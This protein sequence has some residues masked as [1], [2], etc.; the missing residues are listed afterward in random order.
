MMEPGIEVIHSDYPENEQWKRL[1][2]YTYPENVK[3]FW[4]DKHG[5]DPIENQVEAVTSAFTQAA[6]Y[7]HAARAVTMHTLPLLLYYG[8]VNLLYGV[9]CLLRGSLLDIDNHGMTISDPSGT[10]IADVQV[11]LS[12]SKHGAYCQFESVFVDR[13]M[14]ASSTEW[15]LLELFGSIPDL[16]EDFC[17]CYVNVEPFVIPVERVHTNDGDLERVVKKDYTRFHSIGDALVRVPGFTE[18]Y[19]PPQVGEFVI[20]RKKLMGGEIGVYSTSGRKF[21]ALGHRKNGHEMTLPPLLVMFVVLFTLSYLSRYRAVIWNPFVRGDSTGERLFVETLLET[22]LRS[23]PTL[24][25]GA[26]Y[27]RRIQFAR[28]DQGV[29]DRRTI[30]PEAQI[31]S[32]I[33]E[34]LGRS[35]WSLLGEE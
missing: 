18:T 22:C 17:E 13:A 3:R 20:L 6:E 7:F 34:E 16:Y 15:S 9:G 32:L 24:A 2:R 1:L 21:L 19:L 28:A 27:G 25:L 29:V 33:R 31:R 4:N 30:L 10:Q 23:F 5:S 8:A 12:G 26:L 35:S 11:R 14:T